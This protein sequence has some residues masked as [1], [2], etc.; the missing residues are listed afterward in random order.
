[1]F[2]T[3]K[4]WRTLYAVNA[5]AGLLAAISTIVDTSA[6]QC[7]LLETGAYLCLQWLIMLFA[8]LIIAEFVAFI[9]LI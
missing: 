7:T 5:S 4:K 2:P 9:G 3:T 8:C 1:M 6:W